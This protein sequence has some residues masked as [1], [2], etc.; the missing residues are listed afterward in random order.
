MVQTHGDWAEFRFYR[1]DARKVSLAGD[2]NHW[3]TVELPMRRDPDG[4]WTAGLRLA[5]GTHKFRYFADGQWFC[6]YAAFGIEYG[7][8]GPDS[9]VEV[10]VK[11]M[12]RA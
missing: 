2:F 7:P 12:A 9:V 4:Y 3:R 6:D 11:A 1:P 8:F 10:S 5:N